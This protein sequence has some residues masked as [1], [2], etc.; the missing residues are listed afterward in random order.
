MKKNLKKREVKYVSQ[1]EIQQLNDTTNIK[2]LVI[3]DIYDRGGCPN[4]RTFLY[5]GP[6][7]KEII[8]L[9]DNHS[10]GYDEEEMS[11][12]TVQQLIQ[13]IDETN[14][15]GCDFVTIIDLDKG[16]VVISQEPNEENDDE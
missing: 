6:A 13:Q 14:G 7:R 4:M 16:K 5:E 2:W 9:L 15:D 3:A 12:C 8:D 10:Y 11:E 1:K